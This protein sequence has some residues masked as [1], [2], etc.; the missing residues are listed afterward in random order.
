LYNLPCVANISSAFYFLAFTSSSCHSF[1]FYPPPTNPISHFL[2]IPPSQTLTT[3]LYTSARHTRIYRIYRLVAHLSCP[4]LCST[5]SVL[6]YIEQPCIETFHG[7]FACT[8]AYLRYCFFVPFSSSL[9]I[10]LFKVSMTHIHTPLLYPK[11]TLDCIF[12]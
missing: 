10:S 5:M 6:Y 11:L 2:H 4:C 1:L 9:S 8:R 12:L 7:L 3:H